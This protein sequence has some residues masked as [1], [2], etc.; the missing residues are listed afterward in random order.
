MS[1]LLENNDAF[2]QAL[3][4]LNTAQ[5]QA[6][7]QI[8]GPVMVVAGPGT[9]KTQIL[10]ARIGMILTKTDADA[11]NI[12]CLTYTDAGA[13]AMRKRL[14]QFI[15][16]DA[17]RVHIY[18]FHAFCNDIIQQNLDYF[19]KYTLE[20]ISDLE[21]IELYQNLVDAFPKNHILKRFRGD[22][23]YEIPRL[24][25]LFST[26]KREGWTA[27]FI[28]KKVDEYLQ[29][30]EHCEPDSS[31]Y[32]S[33]KYSKK[34]K[35]KNVGDLKPAF[36]EEKEKMERL[37]AA[38]NEFENYTQ[39]MLKRNRYDYD[40]MI[41]WV[42]K[43]FK[44]DAQFLLNYQER[45][46]FIL[47]DEFQDTSGTQNELIQLLIN[48]WERPNI[49]VVGDDDQSIFRFQGA[50]VENI[51][52]FAQ[53]YAAD[54]Y[55]VVLT[56]NYRSSQAILDTAKSLIDRN[57][58]RL[59][60]KLEGLNKHLIAKNSAYADLAA[61]PEIREYATQHHE[62][63]GITN[64]IDTLIQSGVNPAEIAVIYK[65]N[66]SGEALAHYFNLRNIPVNTKRKVDILQLPFAKKLFTILRYLAQE[67]D[68]PYSGDALLFEIMHF[69][70]YDI[71][72]I[73]IAQITKKVQSNKKEWS[74]IRY[75][76]Y[77]NYIKAQTD[78][79]SAAENNSIKRLIEDL[80]FWIRESKNVTLQQ[81]FEKI[82]VRG[83]VLRYIMQSPE[84]MWLMQV[85]T[86]IF[87]FLKEESHKNPGID[88]ADFVN[89]IDLLDKNDLKLELNRALHN[90]QGVNFVTCHGSK[91]L[92]YEYV[93]L[94]GCTASSWEKKRKPSGD[95]KLPD[96]VFS[97]QSTANDQEELRRLFYVALT[98]AKSHLYLSY[99]SYSN[100]GKP[101]EQSIFISELITDTP[102]RI[103]QQQLE[104]E[105]I[106]DYLT[107]QFTEE[108]EPEIEL[109]D[110]HFIENQLQTFALSVTALSNYLDCPLRF[111]FQNLVMVP[112]GKSETMEFGSAVH[113]ALN[114]FFVKMQNDEQ[115]NFPSKEILVE[116]F[117][118][119]MFRHRESFTKEE[120]KRRMEYGEKILPEYYDYGVERWNKIVA[121]EKRISN[122]HV[123]GVPIKGALDKLEFDGKA[124]NVV[125]Y[126]TGKFENAKAKLERPSDKQPNGGD[127]WRQAVFYKILVDNDR[128]NDW[129]AI[130]AEFDFVEPV[131]NEYK[132]ERVYITPDDV[133]IV[134][135][136]IKTV[137]EQIKRH[138][139]SKGC[140][141]SDCQWCTFVKEN[142]RSTV[143][144]EEKEL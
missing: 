52:D 96:T 32:K 91:G 42:L 134:T 83:G 67:T 95:Y 13:I 115:K 1:K 59:V 102:I 108:V 97:T 44:E 63:A 15:G 74:S 57:S 109:M 112:A 72:P 36:E 64:E 117:K 17:Y 3:A 110:T 76:L 120:F 141:K 106:F 56:E 81:L 53:G 27:S 142:Y 77:K 144:P 18:T 8:D 87:D 31:Y 114:Q 68:I 140:G 124:V 21:R 34:T 65:E 98:R 40:D 49:F 136:Q 9:G 19:G 51:L 24:Q 80:E 99:P 79:F 116:D 86:N 58:E 33:F 121:T 37:R 45:Y 122:V 7:E 43:A 10:A 131:K 46:Q 94:M 127:Y 30:I 62:F 28:S 41:G 104:E 138:E 93:F 123:Q 90:E 26:M 12:L 73:E 29:E 55:R 4:G 2:E 47:V 66:K 25:Q 38:A 85:L 118:T 82:I 39:L 111:Y 70:F 126:K 100:T 75:Y 20:P 107:L 69:D 139:F 143:A 14:F 132:N 54:L 130:S 6:V 119:Y 16:P 137:Y 113:F 22:V 48:Y 89:T 60:G 61:Q 103:E 35:D 135:N 5:R 88:L 105:A 101:L 23:Y 50:N 71:K 125:D 133:Q 92:E 129:Q 11:H 78:L 128:S 84:K